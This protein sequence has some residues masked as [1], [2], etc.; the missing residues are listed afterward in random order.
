MS[1]MLR[2]ARGRSLFLLGFACVLLGSAELRLLDLQVLK[3]R[4]PEQS[5]IYRSFALAEEGRRG[6]LLDAR[7]GCLATTV[8]EVD[9]RV[10]T[11][12]VARTTKRDHR[13]ELA[14]E[15]ASLCGIDPEL[16]RRELEEP[17]RWKLLAKGIRDPRVIARLRALTRKPGFRAVTLETRFVREYPRGPLLAPLVGWTGWQPCDRGRDDP[18]FDPEGVVRGVAGLEEQLEE[19]L[20]PT[21]GRRLV[22]RDGRQREMADPALASIEE[23][24]R[25]GQDVTLTIE[26]LAQALAEEAIDGAIAEFSPEWA[27][28]LVLDPSSCDVLAVAQRPTPDSPQPRIPRGADPRPV[29]ARHEFMPAQLSYP[30]GSS[31][32]PLMLGLA[33]DRG[34]VTPETVVDCENGAAAFGNGRERRVIHDTHHF[35]ALD[36]TGV[37]IESSN[38]GI[39]KLVLRVVPEGIRR[40]DPAFQGVLDHLGALGF[41]KRAC[42]FAGE[43]E[44]IVP[45]LKS[46]TRVYTLASLSFGQEIAVTTLQMAAACSALANGGI[47]RAPRFVRGAERAEQR[48]FT[49]ATATALRGM[50]QRVVAEGATGRWKPA[51]WSMGG[52]TGT[53]QN[54]KNHD[55]SITSYWCFAPVNE[56]RFLVLVVLD[57]PKHGRYAAD[58]AAKVAAPLLGRLLE[59]FEVPRDRPEE[60]GE[61]GKHEGRETTAAW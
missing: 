3:A 45:P 15:L 51:G 58:N 37:L 26:P 28:V 30:P 1:T 56:P 19:R 27:Q 23:P 43:A 9:V 54:E 33:L 53:A 21:H 5:S 7:G 29:L 39:A 24:S 6:D 12:G 46:M 57:D 38:I 4:S 34:V 59:R 60:C 31:F 18:L 13:A 10:W 16:T 48:V 44:G 36:V 8:R 35:A 11:S 25:D 20:A 41:G 14:L 52:K 61:Q 32:K 42:G 49:A 17:D 22:H 2:G 47:W 55:L 40:G 50:L